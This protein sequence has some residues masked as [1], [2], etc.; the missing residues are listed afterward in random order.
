MEEHHA[1][2]ADMLLYLVR[3]YWPALAAD[4]ETKVAIAH[5][6]PELDAPDNRRKLV[7]LSD[8]YER[9]NVIA[10]NFVRWIGYE[11]EEAAE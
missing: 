6:L 10:S 5:F 4:P 8:N 9:R 11:E 1:E 7:G 3:F 2:I